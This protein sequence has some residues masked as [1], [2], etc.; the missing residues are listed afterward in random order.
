MARILSDN[1]DADC[2]D[3][4]RG[5]VMSRLAELDG[6]EREI[7]EI[8]SAFGAPAQ[9]LDIAEAMGQG[10]DDIT[11]PVLALLNKSLVR[12]T[13]DGQRARVD[14]LH[15][16]VRECVYESMPEFKR[17]GLHRAIA[18]AL[19]AR[20]L[21][22]VWDPEL[23]SAICR[24]YEAA[25]LRMEKLNQL[26]RELRFHITLNHDLFPMLL[27]EALLSCRIPFSGREE[28]EYKF[29]KAL[30]SLRAL[31]AAPDET[32]APAGSRLEAAYLE[33]RGKYLI[34]WGE[35]RHGR[36]FIDRALAIAR[37]K[38]FDETMMYCQEHICHHFLQT[39]DGPNLEIAGREA[40]RM[41]KRA[42]KENHAG[43]ALR[44]IGA[45]MMIQG[46]LESAEKFF[47][48]SIGVFE[49]LSLLGK[50]YTLNLLAS[51]AYIGEMAQWKG[52]AEGAARHF[53]YCVKRCADAG[54]FWE[55]SHF[56]AH[57]ADAA[58]D[59]GDWDMA[60]ENADAGFA[61]FETSRGVRCGSMLCSVK[62]L[63]DAKRGRWPEAAESLKKSEILSGI[64]KRTW[65]ASY[66]LSRA[67]MCKMAA[68][69]GVSPEYSGAAGDISPMRLASSAES[70]YRA[71]GADKRAGFIKRE[72]GL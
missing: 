1:P 26:L 31:N 42:D 28:T 40:L 12:E 19:N 38:G 32:D 62:A 13:R 20:Y 60:C 66:F 35:Y 45:S 71:I 37:E 6:A 8:L 2:A 4:L 44:F 47:W 18:R 36:A 61:L 3:G 52:D 49:E 17:A 5:V 22:Q 55:S 59:M 10:A 27:D 11:P 16:N 63:C 25:G 29:G 54:L 21:P 9:P 72:F 14:F 30:E 39:D 33:I 41:A 65:R 50:S 69:Q 46:D 34:Y 23:S 64:G 7:L 70:L 51:R 53:G 43:M 57:A 15:A 24:H 68:E 48:K 58:L 67:W 56:Y